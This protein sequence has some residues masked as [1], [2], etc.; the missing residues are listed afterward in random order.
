MNCGSLRIPFAL[1]TCFL[2]PAGVQAQDG[3]SVSNLSP[4]LSTA[5]F[6]E[7]PVDISAT[8]SYTLASQNSG[9]VVL[10]ASNGAFVKSEY[11]GADKGT[12][13]V[14][15]K[16]SQYK[17]SNT[18]NPITVSASLL[19]PSMKGLKI[20]TVGQYAI[21]KDSI[22]FGPEVGAVFPKPGETI[23]Q[24]GEDDPPGKTPPFFA[25]VDY[26]LATAAAGELYLELLTGGG[27]NLSYSRKSVKVTRGSGRA[28]L[29]ID[30]FAMGDEA[31]TELHLRVSIADPANGGKVLVKAPADIV[32]KVQPKPK[33]KMQFGYSLEKKWLQAADPMKLYVVQDDEKY[34]SL[35]SEDRIKGVSTVRIDYEEVELGATAELLVY[36]VNGSKVQL[37]GSIPADSPFRGPSGT[38]LFFLS[39][40]PVERPNTRE[41]FI[42]FRVKYRASSGQEL[43]YDRELVAHQYVWADK[44]FSIPPDGRSLTSGGVYH[45]VVDLTAAYPPSSGFGVHR[46]LDTGVQVVEKNAMIAEWP[47]HLVDKFD[48]PIPDDG[49]WEFVSNDMIVT[50]SLNPVDPARQGPYDPIAKDSLRYKVVVSSATNIAAKSGQ[51]ANVAGGSLSKLSSTQERN[52]QSTKSGQTLASVQTAAEVKP[53]PAVT[54]SLPR[55]TPMFHAVGGPAA[56]LTAGNYIGIPSTWQFDPPIPADGTFSATLALRYSPASLPDDP[57]CS[58]AKLTIVSYDPSTGQVLSYPTTVDTSNH[59]ASTQIDRL[60]PYYSLVVPGPFSQ[61]SLSFPLLNNSGGTDAALTLLNTGKSDA[62]VSLKGFEQKGKAST[63]VSVVIKP[64]QMYSAAASE[65]LAFPDSVPG[66]ARAHIDTTAVQGVEFLGDTKRLEAFS[67]PAPVSS[68]SVLPDIDFNDS[69]S[70]EIHLVNPGGVSVSVTLSLRA[71]DGT[72]VETKKIWLDPYAK[73]AN[74]LEILF[75]SVASPFNGYLLL[76]ATGEINASELLVS[77]Q[78]WAGLSASPLASGGAGATKLYSA[79]F[80]SGPMDYTRLNLVNPTNRSAKLVLRGY[81]DDGTALGAPSITLDSGKQYQKELG[82]L[83][84]L[85]SSQTSTGV[86][87]VESDGS[88]IVGDVTFGD[89]TP[90]NRY[91]SALALTAAPAKSLVI[92]YMAN[93]AAMTTS[94]TVLNASSSAATVQVRVLAADGSAIGST[95]VKVPANGRASSPISKWV[96]AADGQTGGYITLESDQP[97]VAFAGIGP[98]SGDIAAVTAVVP[99]VSAPTVPMSSPVLAVDKT[100]LVFDTVAI[101]QSKAQMLTVSNT[102]TVALTVTGINPAS[103]VFPFTVSPT[104]FTVAAG[105]QQAV[106]VTFKPTAT[107]AVKSSFDFASNDPAQPPVVVA[108]AGTGIAGTVAAPKISVSP[109]SLDFGTVTAGQTKDLTVTLSNSGTATLTVSSIVSSSGNFTIPTTV[110]QVTAGGQQSVTVRF[111]PQVAGAV[112][113]TLTIASNDPDRPTVTVSLSG[114]GQAPVVSTSRID[115][116]PARLDFGT[117]AVGKTKDMD[118]TVSNAAGSATLNVS[119]I[120]SDNAAFTVVSPPIPLVVASVGVSRV[121]VRFAP[122]AVAAALNATLTIKSDAVNLPVVTIPLTG[123]SIAAGPQTMEL[124]VDD[125]VF[126]RALGYDKGGVPGYFVNRLTPPS[127]PATLNK[128]RI[129]FHN[130]TGGLTQYTGISVL[131]GSVVAGAASL[132]GVRLLA[133]AGRVITPGDWNDYDVPAMTIDS[134][135]FVVGFTLNNPPGVLPVAQDTTPPSKGRSYMGTDD[136]KL[137][138]VDSNITQVG[139][140]LIRAVATVGTP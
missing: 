63:P 86:L 116:T 60:L 107:D 133:T 44:V 121:I 77:A 40:H 136:L 82:E 12:H 112:S 102:G 15:L 31:V 126:E 88:G 70:T 27:K 25:A 84:G 92:P 56:V 75:P 28:Y 50:Y 110:A 128:V 46:T 14:T 33:I 76:A 97:L 81:K 64:G 132:D 1:L 42:F 47:Y 105:A 69:W 71:S 100:S 30:P 13:S 18:A 32:Y 79:Q 104:G 68:M 134:G 140:F 45:F 53:A 109:S 35:L 65:V 48:L 10:S 80:V 3:L 117:V 118:L 137:L 51:A 17:F 73:Q 24:L 16:I 114:T 115:V 72:L 113:A 62:K 20:V 123:N 111:A 6:P 55:K 83:F 87:V 127:Y 54:A 108:L 23:L 9:Y 22:S 29:I 124:A 41:D 85:D 66:W 125:G 130:K 135:D 38:R 52:I 57:N 120:S 49:R 119:S 8:I 58:E 94:V 61:A 67:T 139:N 37:L 11:A 96:P 78:S 5:L 138:P 106:T 43:L 21:L 99:A 89:A 131:R 39:V 103:G 93:T 4:S 95:Q 122:T 91:R 101:G 90:A 7:T 36:V 19:D 2:L 129:Y 34:M 74:R 59:T 26:S 98:A